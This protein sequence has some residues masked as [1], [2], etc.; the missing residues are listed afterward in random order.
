[1]VKRSLYKFIVIIHSLLTNIN[2]HIFPDVRAQHC[3]YAMLL[4]GRLINNKG[5][6]NKLLLIIIIDL[7]TVI[8]C[9]NAVSEE[10]RCRKGY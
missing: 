9:E 2:N 3:S 7:K 1:M 4:A 6:N 10:K 8:R 5:N